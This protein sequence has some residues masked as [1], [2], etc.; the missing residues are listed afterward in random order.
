MATG[1]TYPAIFVDSAG[2]DRFVG[3]V[4]FTS[5]ADQ[6]AQN[7]NPIASGTLPDTSAWVSGTAKVNPVSRNITVAVEVVTDG[8]ANAATCAI[9]ISPNDSDYTAIGTPGV[10]SAVNTVGAVTLVSCV[11]L[12]Q[13]WYIKLTLSHATVAASYYW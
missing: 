4:L 10:S 6:P 3:N 13:G 5:S 8:T 1:E 7:G 2:I 9:E 12:P 11:P